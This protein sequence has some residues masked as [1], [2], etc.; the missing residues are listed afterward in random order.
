MQHGLSHSDL[1]VSLS[2]HFTCYVPNQRGRGQSGLTG[3]NYSIQKEVED[4]EAIHV[5]TGAEFIFGVSSGALITLK[6][7][8]VAPASHIKKIAVFEPPWW[9]ESEREQQT[10]WIQRYEEEVS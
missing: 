5:A 4:V 1:E 3:K 10:M 8:P 2:E 7:A 6:A 9:P